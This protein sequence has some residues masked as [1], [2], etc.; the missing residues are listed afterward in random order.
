MSTSPTSPTRG[1]AEITLERIQPWILPKVWKPCPTLS[2]SM[3]L[4][5]YVVSVMKPHSLALSTGQLE[6]AKFEDLMES[7]IEEGTSMME[8]WE[9][10][11]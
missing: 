4:G 7:K 10:K 6:L 8:N 5:S 3:S 11:S 2:S 9:A 1:P